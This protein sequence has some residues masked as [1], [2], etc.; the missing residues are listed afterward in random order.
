MLRNVNDY[1]IG[2]KAGVKYV[3]IERQNG[4]QYRILASYLTTPCLNNG[5]I[6][7]KV[8]NVEPPSKTNRLGVRNLL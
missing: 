1:Q 2:V 3:S 8:L 4:Q 7:N 5:N 6:N